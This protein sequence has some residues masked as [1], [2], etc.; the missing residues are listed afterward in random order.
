MARLAARQHAVVSRSQLLAIG[1]SEDA[2]WRRVKT[3]R[4][5][6]VH[7]G[8]YAVGHPLLFPYTHYMAAVLACGADAVASHRSAGALHGLCRPPS[9]DI[10]VIVPRA[11]G[12]RRR[13]ITVHG[14]RSLCPTEIGLM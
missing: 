9:G 3:G 4:L 6:R 7:A 1:L 8:V 10:E 11:G 12:R 5:H 13:G 14:T 2:I